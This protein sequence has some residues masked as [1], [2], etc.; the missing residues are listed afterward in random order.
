M[1]KQPFEE[2]DNKPALVV[3]VQSIW[4]PILAIIMLVVGLLGGYFIRPYIPRATS[5]AKGGPQETAVA[6]SPGQPQK[7]PPAQPTM[8]PAD[9]QKLEDTLVKQT[10]H[11][12]GDPN[13]PVTIIE[14]SD[15]Q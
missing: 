12:K 3:N 14:F 10:R 1:E 15:F 6:Q 11:F 2:S 7:T 5:G 9:R 4:T 8:S 13:A